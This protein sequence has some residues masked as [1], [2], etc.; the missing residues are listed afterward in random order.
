MNPAAGVAVWP[1]LIAFAVVVALIPIVLAL[2]KRTQQVRPNR[3][4]MLSLVGGLNVGTRE[5][6]AVVATGGKWLIV[7]VTPQSINLLA[8]LDEPPH[9]PEP[10]A[11]TPV[12]FSRLLAGFKHDARKNA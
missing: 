1:S 7:G 10:A 5:R 6:I 9:D 2:I 3:Q 4:G 8:T 12:A 11:T